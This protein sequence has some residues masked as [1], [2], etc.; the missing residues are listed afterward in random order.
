MK[1]VITLCV[2]TIAL[3]NISATNV[4]HKGSSGGGGRSSRGSSAKGGGRHAGSGSGSGSHT[5][6]IDNSSD[7][8]V[9]SAVMSAPS[10]QVWN[11]MAH[12][13]TGVIGANQL[14]KGTM[15]CAKGGA[16]CLRGKYEDGLE[17][18]AEGCLRGVLGVGCAYCATA[19]YSKRE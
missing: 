7:Y 1:L 6:I 8:D 10:P 17:D 11:D 13:A 12:I 9:S 18:C 14:A 5:T 15:L 2:L 4:N 19:Y 3:G 16:N